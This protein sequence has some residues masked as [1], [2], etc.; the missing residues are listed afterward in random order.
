M[1]ACVPALVRH[2]AY[3]GKGYSFLT[4]SPSRGDSVGGGGGSKRRCRGWSRMCAPPPG[5][6]SSLGTEKTLLPQSVPPQVPA[7]RP[8]LPL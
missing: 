1:C 3:L 6:G 5:P 7:R 2:D 8:G 4:H